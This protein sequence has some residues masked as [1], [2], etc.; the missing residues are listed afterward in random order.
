MRVHI[1]VVDTKTDS[2]VLVSQ[3]NKFR[4]AVS[5]RS[6]LDVGAESETNWFPVESFT[7]LR[8]TP[9]IFT[10]PRPEAEV[11]LRLLF[12]QNHV[13]GHGAGK[14]FKALVRR[15]TSFHSLENL[16]DRFFSQF[17]TRTGERTATHQ[18]KCKRVGTGEP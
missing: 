1:P 16:S 10:R 14:L 17:N 18:A 5:D 6:Q 11:A 9:R 8:F 2:P 15:Q 12:C 3:S 7:T 4:V 13:C